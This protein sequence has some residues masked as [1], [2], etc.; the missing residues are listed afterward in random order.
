MKFINCLI[1]LL[2]FSCT[3]NAQAFLN[4]SFETN[5]AG[6]TNRYNLSN[7]TFNGYMSDATSF[8]GASEIDIVHSS[9]SYGT[10]SYG[11]YCVGLTGGAHDSFS[12]KLAQPLQS[13]TSYTFT[14][15]VYRPNS[16]ATTPDTSYIGLS[17]S[18]STFGT[19]IYTV[20]PPSSINAWVQHTVTFTAPNNG[21]YITVC[22][23]TTGSGTWRWFDNFVGQPPTVTLDP[24]GDT[25]CAGTNK[26]LIIT[27]INTSSY[28]W[29]VHNGSSWSNLSNGGVYSGTTD[30]TLTITGATIAIDNYQ[31]RCIATDGNGNYD[32]SAAARLGVNALPT[33]TSATGAT[34][35]TGTT[36][37]V[38]ATAS[39][40]ATIEWY[41]SSSGGTLLHSGDTLTIASPI[42]TK[43][44]YAGATTAASGNLAGSYSTN[45]GSR[46]VMFDVTPATTI[47]VTGF[48]LNIY[49]GTAAYEIYYKVGTYVGSESNSGSWTLLGSNSSLT[50]NGSNV[51]TPLGINLSLTL[52]AGQTYGFYI[53]NSNNVG[54]IN[55][56]TSGSPGIT[57]ASN[58]TLTITGGVGK[59]YPFGLTYLYRLFSGAIY[60][61]TNGCSSATRTGATLTVNPIPAVT[62]HPS[63]SSI[64]S[65]G[66]TSFSI[67]ATNTTS[68]QWQV[69][70]GSSWSNVTNT[71]IYS[72]ATTAML[73]LTAATT[74]VNGYLYRCIASSSNGCTPDTSNDGTLA[75]TGTAPSISAHP[76]NA[77]ICSGSNTTFSVTASGTSLSYQWEVHNGSSWSNVTNT[78]IYTGATTATLTL[79]GASSAVNSYQYRCVVT[80]SVSP[81]ATS[82]AATLTVNTAPAISTHPFNNTI[83]S[84]G[85][86]TF[87]VGATGSSL[88]YQ[89]QVHNGSSWSN[90]TNTGIYTGATTA[91]LT[92]TG[93]TT[94]VN[95]YQYRCVVSGTCTPSATSNAATLTI[96]TAPAISAHPSNSTICSGNNTTFNVTA[97]GS[98]LT[99]QWEVHNGSSWSNVTNTGIYTGATTNTLTLTGATTAVNTYQYRCVV[100]GACTPSATSNA[101]TLTINTVPAVTVHPSNSTICSGNTT[102]SV[103][104]T[105]SSLTYQWEVHN[106]SSW[107]NVTNTGI[108]TGA[109]TNTLTLTGATSAVNAYQY[110]CV[111][112]GGC[113]PAATSNAATLSVNSAPVVSVHPSNSTIGAGS[114]TSFNVTAT[115]TSIT[116]QWQVNDGS[117]WSN[118]TNTGIYSGATTNALSLTT[119]SAAYTTYQY[120]CVVSGPCTPAATSNAAT[121][122]VNSAPAI[123]AQPSNSTICSGTNTTFSVTASNAVSYQW[124]VHNGSAWSNV[125]NTGIYTG[126]TTNTLTLTGATSAINTYQYRCE[127]TGLTTPNAISN[128]ATL[129][130]NTAPAITAQPSNSTICS[131]SNTTF[132]VA[133]MGTT[134]TYQWEVHNGSSWSNVTN[135]GIYTGATTNTL[136]LTGATSAVNTYQYRCVVS[137]TCTPDATSNTATLTINSAPVVT[138]HPGDSTICSGTNATFSISATGSSLAYQWQVNDGSGWSNM[139]NT[140]IYSGTTTS[141]LTLTAATTSVHTYQYR[142]VVNGACTP[143]D[144]SNAAIITVNSLPAITLHPTNSTIGAGSNTSFSIT[145]TGTSL[146]YQWQVNDGSG[147]SN[148]TNTG[149]YTGATSNTLNLTTVSA[150]YTTYQ[151]RCVVSGVCAP[152]ATS[153]AATLTVNS[154]PAITAQPSDSTICSGTN[155]TFSV[156]ASNAVSYQWQVNDGSGWSNL[157]NT[158]IYSGAT[159][160]TLTLTGA[161]AA[162][163]TYQYRC[164]VTGLTTP[165]AISNAGILTVNVA[166]AVTAQ[167]SN[168]TI[169]PGSNTA[170][171]VTATGTTLTYQWQ[172]NDGSSWSNLTNTGIYTGVTS[173]TLT[174]TGATSTVNTYQYRCVVSG[175]CTPSATSSGATLTINPAPAITVHPSGSTICPGGN[176][177]ISV[178]AS[179]TGLTYQWEVNDGSGWTNLSNTGIYSGSATNTLNLTGATTAISSYQYRCVVSGT[180]TPSATSNAATITFNAPPAITQHPANASACD[181]SNTSFSVTATGA[182]LT[183]QWQVNDGSGWSNVANT[184][185]YS[186]ATTS[187]LTLTGVSSAVDGYQYRC[188]VNGTCTPQ[189]TSN[190][191][192]LSISSLLTINTHPANT[193]ICTGNNTTFTVSA[194]GAGLTYQ[195]QVN[196]G[197]GWSNLSNTG[198]Y[199]DATT[200]TLILTGAT[201]TQNSY[202]YRCVISSTCTAPANSN[203]GTLTIHAAPIVTV[204]PANSTICSGGN[205]TFGITATGNG[206]TYQ[207]QEYN[208]SGWSNLS[209]TGIYSGT[210]T[211]ILSLTGATTTVNAYQYRCIATSSCTLSDTSNAAAITINTAPV[212]TAHPLNT[213]ACDGSNTSFSITAT[214]AGLTYQWQVND[215]SGW[216]NISNT[217]IYSGATTGSLALTGATSAV[218]NYQYRCI[219]GGTCAPSV[220]GNAATL[221]INSLLTINTHPANTSACSGNNTSFSVVA[222]GAGVT[223]QWQE[224][225][226]SGWTNLSNSGIYSDVTT[227]TLQLT[228]ATTSVNTYQYRC[229]VS[230]SCTVPTNTN[231]AT[232]TINVAPVIT[233]QPS[234]STICEGVNTSFS[235]AATGAG[236]TYQWEVNDGSGWTN[237]SN[238]G[239]YSGAMSNTLLV[240]APTASA[241]N[242]QYRC[243]VGGT[244][245]P[246]VVSSAATLTINTA[247][248]VITQP[249]NS[250]ICSGSSTSFIISATG[251]SLSYQW[252]VNDGS[253][254]VNLF[255]TGIY[256][257][258]TSDTLLLT[259]TTTAVNTYQYRCRV[260]GVCTPVATSSSATITVN[261]APAISLQPTNST[262]CEGA[263][264]SFNI[265]ATGTGITYQW[266]VNDGSGWA[267]L[268]NTGMYSGVTSNALSITMAPASVSGYQYRCVTGGTCVPGV[269]SSSAT[270]TVNTAPVITTQP[271]NSTICAGNNTVF[272]VSATGTG[273]TYQWQVHNGSSWTNITNAGIYSGAT[274]DTLILTAASASVNGY[275][276]RCH[277]SGTC[278]PQATSSTAA[279]TVNTAPALTLQPANSTICEGTNTSFSIN[280]A[281]TGLSYQWEVYDGSTWSNVTNS[282]I[283]SGAVTNTLTLTAATSAVNGYQYRCSVNGACVP[284]IV[285]SAATLTIHAAPVII[286]QPSG[287]TI[288]SGNNTSFTVTA[289]GTSLTYQWQ[290]NDGSGWANLSNA[291]IYSGAATNSLNLTAATT[292]V[293]NYQYRCVV[294]G[295]CTP[296]TTSAG[297]V[298]VVNALPAITAQPSASTICEGGNTTFSIGATGT[299][300]TYQ[301]QV[302]NG[303]GWAN[304]SNAGIYNGVTTNTLSLTAATTAVHNYQ[305]RCVAGGTCTPAVISNTATLTIH[306]SPVITANPANKTICE[307][308]VHNFTVAATGTALT[309]QWQ[310]NNGGGWTNLFNTGIYSGATTSSL[311]LTNIPP[312][313]NN[314]QYRCIVSGACAP[315]ATSTAATLVVNTNPVVTTQPAAITTICSG[316]NTGFSLNATGTGLSY[317]WRVFNGS[318]WSNVSNGG[319]YGGA[320]TT[321]L[322]VSGPLA[323]TAAITYKYHCVITGTCA[324]ANSDTSTLV[325]NARP[326]IT[327]NPV[328]K[329]VCDST[330]NVSFTMDATGTGL[331]YQWQ[332]NTGTG[333]NNLSNNSTYSGVFSKQLVIAKAFFSM[334]TFQYRCV[335][336]GSCTPVVTTSAALFTV[337][338]LKTP[339]VTIAASNADICVGTS[340]TFTPTSV[341]GGTTPSYVWK[342]NGN[343]VGTAGTYTSATLADND[344]V[345]CIMASSYV[346]PVP[347]TDTSNVINMKVTPYSTPTISVSSPT[348]DKGCL[349][350]PVYFYSQVTNEGLT[351]DYT[352]QVNGTT[353]GTNIDTF[354][355]SSLQNGDI[356]KCI[357]TSSLK[358]PMPKTVTSNSITMD[359]IPV[360]KSSIVIAAGP[361]TNICTNEKVTLRTWY[362]NGGTTPAYQWMVNGQDLVGETQGSF[363]TT[364]LSDNDIVTCRFI[365]SARCVFPELSNEL[366][367]DVDAIKTTSV[368]VTVYST[369][370]DS[371]TFKALPQNGGTNPQFQWYKNNS[372][373]PGATDSIYIATGI[374]K[375]DRITVRMTSSLECVSDKAVMSENITTGITATKNAEIDL[376]LYPNPNEGMFTISVEGMETVKYAELQVMNAIGQVVYQK[377]VQVERGRFT[378]VVSLSPSNTAGAYILQLTAD[379]KKLIQRFVL[380]E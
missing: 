255:N 110:R 69:H 40:G 77:A 358:C 129:T 26:Q 208:G 361:D 162:I 119:V 224:N 56:T 111:V 311:A 188:V 357:L 258:A 264:T 199:S 368:G 233:S 48:D 355:T 263:N 219:A 52:G 81:T 239:I 94:S 18:A 184:G 107:S 75:V 157:A 34:V 238:V 364:A 250:T 65:G 67:T 282:G 330:N 296:A 82:N 350:L 93:A 90:V 323:P 348:G 300:L 142:C 133:A 171:S 334:N 366:S 141:T 83:C 80:G 308:L 135:T 74:T 242:N 290:V 326:A 99:Y 122:T 68:Y 376:K 155:A 11:S 57:I 349:G 379:S 297:A 216:S 320:T 359:I 88:T 341:N 251:S 7:T 173:N 332:V 249:S 170:F 192:T 25:I 86:T 54:G 336:Q 14:F 227:A 254:W 232:L 91:T 246:G 92:L 287:S 286:V 70:N 217:S 28:Q 362:T 213:S 259:G 132:T 371:Y 193:T 66:N 175:V 5:T 156:T 304:L 273:L 247:P 43:T 13:G 44:Y 372:T 375:Y 195:W 331:T 293:H 153:T 31:Y 345:S 338:E 124:Q 32:T 209:N 114:N 374:Q 182:G 24:V 167:P 302:N 221:S 231:A 261:T 211:N 27:A 37:K 291:G 115:G 53:T 89:W 137:G 136:T 63:N 118:V 186:G 228:G 12:L 143:D 158:G 104:A 154:A 253:G 168:S 149:I 322:T 30:D 202:Q 367:F 218:D 314:Y 373:I 98:S 72:G 17:T 267:N 61:E 278:V 159:T 60:Y 305:Y 201:N 205:T 197:S 125:T 339:T 285:S 87:S 79:T 225:D 185:I 151:Y 298:L 112:S 268:A 78:G 207:W 180:C 236:I 319:L 248:V 134:L 120:R 321:A 100:S 191:A 146:T 59:T 200:A 342:I 198:I 178:T 262:I 281:G 139:A 97:T 370:N 128:A 284:G 226:G 356:V 15:Y 299:G 101:A 243:I 270:L 237:V 9:T 62:V 76:S 140:G 274:T 229:V 172:V 295:A 163:S 206:L 346:C 347:P 275:L 50:S 130:V 47:T 301:W 380:A 71:G 20:A 3:V 152:P 312:S 196:D 318:T 55:Y 203:A 1:L 222:T 150:A 51:A 260:S 4:G 344:K 138:T 272:G 176:T 306:T 145:A 280:A 235:I 316:D 123:T 164:E 325:V 276:Y 337:Y 42:T 181:G 234:N 212:I 240:T 363:I 160:A 113:T 8:G 121:L 2:G 33:V 73:T 108:Y 194:S 39:S 179:G 85:N 166:P 116:Y 190:A 215:G 329:A 266:Q 10:V 19:L 351:P 49:P 340:V 327:L 102:F 354:T 127:V 41:D 333:W 245:V 365:S 244:C 22:G 117:G 177:S 144:T 165:D 279:L 309:Y 269:M 303:T 46:G 169:C 36:G 29:Q 84:G 252:Q 328:N 58:S 45:N 307:G 126:A 277:I 360:T 95:T 241:N 189:A 214:G 161:T 23:K 257:G 38:R 210:A 335:V 369:G 289:A 315:S 288:C 148:V 35:C 183:Y 109:T 230:S 6:G 187:T 265:T 283:Y 377:E 256:S 21:Q 147:W 353:V 105:G 317:Q 313:V 131:G 294:S 106:G 271:V 220:T 343:T 352:W 292:T 103:T 174:L 96:N 378:H 310:V 64:T 324:I 204:D 16:Y 223:Y